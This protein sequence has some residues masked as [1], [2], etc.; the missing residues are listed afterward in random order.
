MILSLGNLLSH[1]VHHEAN[2]PDVVLALFGI[3]TPKLAA[4]QPGY[5]GV[6][7]LKYGAEATYS[8]YELVCCIRQV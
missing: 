1:P 4:D 6:K 8:I 5:D 7:K 3:F 2:S